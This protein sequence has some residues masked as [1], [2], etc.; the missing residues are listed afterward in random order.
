MFISS[1]LSSFPFAS[2]VVDEFWG[3]LERSKIIYNPI[4]ALE[5][6]RKKNRK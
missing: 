3:K 6:D 4:P 5:L 1:S 2:G